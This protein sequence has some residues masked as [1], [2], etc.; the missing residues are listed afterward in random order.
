[1]GIGVYT[2]AIPS[3][4]ITTIRSRDTDTLFA[5]TALKVMNASGGLHKDWGT[6]SIALGDRKAGGDVDYV[7]AWRE[8]DVPPP[9]PENS[10]GGAVYWSYL[11]VN[12]GHTDS[13]WTAVFNKACDAIAG[14]IADQVVDAG[15]INVDALAGLASLL[16]IQELVNLLT[17]DCDGTVA[18]GAFAYTAAQLDS[19]LPNGTQTTTTVQDNP[20]PSVEGCGANS[21]YQVEYLIQN[22]NWANSDLTAI[23]STSISFGVPAVAGSALDG[24]WDGTGQHVNYIDASG[25]VRELYNGPNSSPPNVWLDSDLTAIASTS[26]SFGVPAVAGSALD[27]YWDG[28]GQHVNYIDASGHVRELYNGPNSSPP[29]VWLDSDLTAIA[30][31]S[32]SFGVPAVAGSA[33]D[34]YWDGTGQHVNYIDASGHVREL[35]NGPNSSPPNVWLDSDLTAIASTSISFGVPA[36]AGSALDGYWDGTGQHVNYIDASGHVRELYN[37]PNSSPPNVWLD[38]DLTAIA[39][40]SIS[41]GVPAVAGSALDG[42]WDATGQHVNYIDASGHVRELYNGPNSSPP[43]VW[44]DSDLTAVTNGVPA[45]PE[46]H[47]AGY[48]DGAGQHVN[49][50]GVD[51]H[52]HELYNGFFSSGWV[53]NDLSISADGVTP[54]IGSAIDG[55]WDAGA[56][57]VNYIDAGGHV[58]ELYNF[59]AV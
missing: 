58:H 25:H 13:G 15:E 32:I 34:G 17:G 19:M 46:S 8:V 1:M 40:T 31:T 21:D 54:V 14:A 49:Y 36:V 26:I 7:M 44:L 33:L 50:I 16:G 11:L 55:Y 22:D 37:G 52:V 3:F 4:H 2:F 29:N 5:S 45:V 56:G 48:W 10:D 51:G 27:G 18:V 59:S 57:H 28:T 53:D 39:S 12:N 38:S 35:Y 9:T 23:A 6:Q 24:Y 42:Y 47:L 30:S 43:N 20:G 41:F